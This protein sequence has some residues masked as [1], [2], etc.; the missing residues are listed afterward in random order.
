MRAEDAELEAIVAEVSE[1]CILPETPIYRLRNQ[2]TKPKPKRRAPQRRAPQRR[3]VR[4]P[5]DAD[6]VWPHD[7][8][9]RNR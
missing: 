7:G 5:L 9:G 1:R 4:A 3:A 8:G 6:K 2:P